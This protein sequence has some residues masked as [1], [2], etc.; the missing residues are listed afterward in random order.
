MKGNNFQT[1]SKPSKAI[2]VL[3]VLVGLV[4]LVLA[5]LLQVV[6]VPVAL[7]GVVVGIAY[8]WLAML[9]LWGVMKLMVALPCYRSGKAILLVLLLLKIG[10]FYGLLWLLFIFE[11]G[12]LLSVALGSLAILPTGMVVALYVSKDRGMNRP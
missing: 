9:L 7:L 4:W 11:R 5:T 2:A 6:G 3:V 12:Q 8:L 10:L 1:V